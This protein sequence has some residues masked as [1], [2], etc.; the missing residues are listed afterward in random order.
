MF[1]TFGMYCMC[2][3]EPAQF[4]ITRRKAVYRNNRYTGRHI[5]SVHDGA[6]ITLVINCRGKER[7]IH[8]SR[9]NVTYED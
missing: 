9:Q 4:R 5:C 8:A 2:W 1:Q 6:D 3:C 7:E